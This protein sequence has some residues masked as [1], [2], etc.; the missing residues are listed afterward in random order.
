MSSPSSNMR[1]N[2]NEASKAKHTIFGWHHHFTQYEIDHEWSHWT[3]YP[4]IIFFFDLLLQQ[5]DQLYAM[6]PALL[7]SHAKFLIEEETIHDS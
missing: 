3:S 1:Q 2:K 4:A 5:S 6:Q 7:V